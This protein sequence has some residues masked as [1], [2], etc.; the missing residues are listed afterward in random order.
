MAEGKLYFAYG[1][2]INL[3]QMAQRC[4]D[5]QVVGPVTLENYELLFRGNLR[6]AG[7]ATIAPRE[8]ST[9]HGLLWNITPE[10]ERSLDYYEGYPHLY[11][12]EP[13][14]VHGHDGQEHTVMAYVM[15]E[16]CK[17]PSIPSFYYYN[18]ILEGYRQNGLPTASLKQ[19]WEH[20]VEEVHRETERINAAP[21]ASSRPDGRKTAGDKPQISQEQNLCQT[22]AFP[23]LGKYIS[24]QNRFIP[25]WTHWSAEGHWSGLWP[26]QPRGRT[27]RAA[28]PP[29]R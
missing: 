25:P 23:Y 6:G 27:P 11:G 18:G 5:A 29:D 17:E 9:V 3:D 8:G 14:T 7:V 20:C 21:A 13:V 15:T 1:S 28:C 24:A 19:A 26:L 22:K 10:C 12:K 16:L 4:P 2:N